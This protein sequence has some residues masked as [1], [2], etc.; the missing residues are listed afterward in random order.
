MHVRKAQVH[1]WKVVRAGGMSAMPAGIGC[2]RLSGADGLS[3]PLG[4]PNRFSGSTLYSAANA[5]E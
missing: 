3:E 4:T 2:L 1:V 5:G